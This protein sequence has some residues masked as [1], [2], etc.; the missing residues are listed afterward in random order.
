[1]GELRKVPEVITPKHNRSKLV[2][3]QKYI[4][5]LTIG[6]EFTSNAVAVKINFMNA[7]SAQGYLRGRDDVERVRIGVWRRVK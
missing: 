3:L 1:M 7:A 2:Q 5:N 4:E 6:E